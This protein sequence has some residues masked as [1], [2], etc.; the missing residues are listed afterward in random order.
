MIGHGLVIDCH[1]CVM[2]RCGIVSGSLF[3]TY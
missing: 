2:V 3:I 1:G